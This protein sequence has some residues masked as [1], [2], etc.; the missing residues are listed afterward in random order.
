MTSTDSST[1]SPDPAAAASG[2]SGET[3]QRFMAD[4]L[5]TAAPL[6]LWARLRVRDALRQRI[7]PEDVVQET[8]VR[9]FTDYA[10]FDPGRGS[11]R[12]WI[13][14]IATHVWLKQL[15]ALHQGE[16]DAA[17]AARGGD[18]AR[19]AE[20][21]SLLDS[22]SS[23]TSKVTRREE[24]AAVAEEIGRLDRDERW[25][26]VFRGLERLGFTEIGA[27][28]VMHPEAARARWRRLL[29]KLRQRPNLLRF[30][31]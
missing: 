31:D 20:V 5:A 19:T 2:S 17:G 23:I 1:T 18:G 27:R 13:F 11:F 6:Q 15:R 28:M 3:V 30:L 29:A 24:L 7:D 21:D 10:R 12:A 26:L 22:V 25:L 14:G 9:A 16:A 8:C 4:F